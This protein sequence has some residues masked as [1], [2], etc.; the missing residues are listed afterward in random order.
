MI[1]NLATSQ[2]RGTKKNPG[3]HEPYLKEWENNERGLP[4]LVHVFDM[5]VY[6]CNILGKMHR[7]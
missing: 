7:L 5:F 6:N 1:A 4:R 3:W 2:N